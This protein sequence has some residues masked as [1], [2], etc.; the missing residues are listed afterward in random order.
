MERPSRRSPAW[1]TRPAGPRGR[2]DA[3]WR[4]RVARFRSFHRSS[5]REARGST[6]TATLGQAEDALADDVALDLARPRGDRVLTGGEHAV[7]PAWG[8]GHQL[9]ALVH[10]RVHAEELAR[11]IRDAHA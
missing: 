1:A 6:R 10:Q 7:E 4:P 11:R 2:P 5:R 3:D 9:G 8:V